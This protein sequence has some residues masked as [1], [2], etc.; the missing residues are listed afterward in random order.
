MIYFE[1]LVNCICSVRIDVCDGT[2]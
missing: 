2:L 1:E